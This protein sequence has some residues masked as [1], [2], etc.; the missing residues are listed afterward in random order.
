MIG[1][2]V[3]WVCLR[4]L[5]LGEVLGTRS[6][7]ACVVGVAAGCDIVRDDAGLVSA[8]LMGLAVANMRGFDIP[9]LRPL[10]ET[11]VHHCRGGRWVRR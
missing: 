10:F 1:V 3:R 9:S 5:G 2:A 8:I 11:Q 7:L 4:R 6:H